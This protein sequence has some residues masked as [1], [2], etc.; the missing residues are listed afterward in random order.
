ME[1]AVPP[2]ESAPD[3]SESSD[4]PKRRPWFDRQGIIQAHAGFVVALIALLSSYDHISLPAGINLQLQQQWG[5]WF[6]LASM[7]LV[8]TDAQLAR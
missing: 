2:A 5:V 4:S 6:I 1:R 3:S 8:L 7:A